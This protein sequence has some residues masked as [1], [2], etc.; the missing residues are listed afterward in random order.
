MATPATNEP[1]RRS[2]PSVP[3]SVITGTVFAL[4]VVAGAIM[5][6]LDLPYGEGSA[7]WKPV[8]KALIVL[9]WVSDVLFLISLFLARKHRTRPRG[10]LGALAGG[11]VRTVLVVLGVAFLITTPLNLLA[12]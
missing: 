6:E 7:T 9:T 3:A 4:C 11:T 2:G 5:L 1:R 12:S 10:R 8:F